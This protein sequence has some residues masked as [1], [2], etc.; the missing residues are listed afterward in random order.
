MA[1]IPRVPPKIYSRRPCDRHDY[2]GVYSY[3]IGM[4]HAQ[5]RLVPM[6]GGQ[7]LPVSSMKTEQMSSE[8]H[9]HLCSTLVFKAGLDRMIFFVNCFFGFLCFQSS[10]LLSSASTHSSIRA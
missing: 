9:P 10:A 4:L 5:F 7:K 1:F 6:L 2:Q 8:N 3:V